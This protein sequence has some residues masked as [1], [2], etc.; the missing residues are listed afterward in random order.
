[1]K[2][3]AMAEIPQSSIRTHW[4]CSLK[5]SKKFIITFLWV[6]KKYKFNTL[7]FFFESF[8]FSTCVRKKHSTA[9]GDKV[10]RL[11][12]DVLSEAPWHVGCTGEARHQPAAAAGSNTILN[13]H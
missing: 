2:Q 6:T 9:G 4:S 7:L 3:G 5:A 8:C 12:C 1:L 10:Q 13:T 11:W